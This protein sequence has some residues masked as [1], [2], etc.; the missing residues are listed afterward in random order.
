MLK[1]DSKRSTRTVR[2]ILDQATY[3][4]DKR[5]WTKLDKS[6]DFSNRPALEDK[7]ETDGNH[8]W[9]APVTQ[10]RPQYLWSASGFGKRTLGRW[11]QGLE[12][13][14]HSGL[15]RNKSLP[16]QQLIFNSSL[17]YSSMCAATHPD[18][19]M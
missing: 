16:R 17:G 10:F 1:Q 12:I 19:F 5:R 13:N 9:A 14:N 4:N 7:A 11:V 3:L 2:L 6:Q 18:K 8:L 15:S